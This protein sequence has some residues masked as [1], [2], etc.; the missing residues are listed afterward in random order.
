LRKLSEERG[1]EIYWIGVRGAFEGKNIPTLESSAIP[2]Q[3]VVFH[4]IFAGRLQKKFTRWT[5]PS[6]LKIPVGFLHAVYLLLRIKPKVVLSFGG[7]AAF[8]VV[9]G[10]WILR[11]PVIIHEQTSVV[12]RANKFSAPLAKKIAISRESSARFFSKDKVVVTGNPLM[13]Q[14]WEVDAKSVLSDP[15]VVFITGGSRGSKPVNNLI[16]SVLPELLGKYTLIHQTGHLDFEKFKI[17]KNK[18]SKNAS[19]RYEIYSVIDP[20]Q[21]DGVYKR[22]DIVVARAGANT[23][24]EIMAVGRPAILIPIPWTAYDEQNKNAE[25]AKDYCDVRILAQK[26]AKGADLLGLID[27]IAKDYKKPV[28]K[29]IPKPSPDIGA[30]GKLVDLVERCVR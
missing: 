19:G 11:I 9:I 17:V 29:F 8:P 7:F 15:P 2:A 5:I 14:I 24:A 18:L 16:E 23:V 6:M 10:S 20:M 4:S 3:G 25:F 13:T 1:W 30:A 12:G 27:S 21:M 28:S 26:S 22:A